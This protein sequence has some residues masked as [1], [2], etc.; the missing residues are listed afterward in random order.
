[1]S[2]TTNNNAWTKNAESPSIVERLRNGNNKLDIGMKLVYDSKSG[3]SNVNPFL[4]AFAKAVNL[5]QELFSKTSL[6]KG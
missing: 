2:A 6:K 1:M 5:S 3:V 4:K